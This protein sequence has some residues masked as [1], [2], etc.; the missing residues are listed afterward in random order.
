MKE[1]L[2]LVGGLI[3]TILLSAGLIILL[4]FAI[5]SQNFIMEN[6][7]VVGTFESLTVE[8]NNFTLYFNNA[9]IDGLYQ[10][11]D[12]NITFFQNVRQG[13]SLQ[14][15][16]IIGHRYQCVF[17]KAFADQNPVLQAVVELP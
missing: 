17:G 9:T 2:K 14:V 8:Q 7:M 6:T 15:P 3:L 4:L 11:K 10:A 12:Y 16:F 13:G 5:N 1:E